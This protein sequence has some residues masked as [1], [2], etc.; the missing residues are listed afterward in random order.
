MDPGSHRPTTSNQNTIPPTLKGRVANKRTRRFVSTLMAILLAL[1]IAGLLWKAVSGVEKPQPDRYQAVFLDNG[2]V[3]FG[4]LKNTAGPYLKLEKSY[5]TQNQKLPENATEEQKAATS[6]NVSLVKFG[7]EVY[8]LDDT[9]M[10][11]AEQVLFWQNLRTDSKV[12]KAMDN[13]Q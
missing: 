11:R 4:K 6:N 5:Y 9:L 2:Q 13:A 1:L 10:I 7:K 12:S 3:F 8:G